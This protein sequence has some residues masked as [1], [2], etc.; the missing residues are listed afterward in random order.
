MMDNDICVY[1]FNNHFKLMGV[2]LI[3]EFKV[4]SR[5]TAKWVESQLLCDTIID[6][7]AACNGVA[8]F[9]P[10]VSNGRKNVKDSYGYKIL[11]DFSTDKIKVELKFYLT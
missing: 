1:M 8:N 3:T 6:L 9:Y 10:Y 7:E 4:G 5:D 2:D 11:E